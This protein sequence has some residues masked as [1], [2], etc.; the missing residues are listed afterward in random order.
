MHHTSNMNLV[1]GIGIG[2]VV[3]SA[4]GM[5][6]SPKGHK[7]SRNVVGKTLKTM[8]EIIDHVTGTFSM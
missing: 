2:I 3:G 6:V 5:V 4:I 1:K 7:S 8:G